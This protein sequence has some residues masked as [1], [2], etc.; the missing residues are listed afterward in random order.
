MSANE[1]GRSQSEGDGNMAWK[2]HA[3][4]CNFPSLA[5]PHTHTFRLRKRNFTWHYSTICIAASAT[6]IKTTTAAAKFWQQQQQ[7]HKQDN[8]KETPFH[9]ACTHTHIGTT[10]DL[11]TH[12]STHDEICLLT[13]IFPFPV[14]LSFP[15]FWHHALLNFSLVPFT[16]THTRLHIR[17]APFAVAVAMS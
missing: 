9:W 4:A 17:V 6:E 15:P 11:F 1:S 7:Q 13:S 14:T 5:P 3:C 16:H 10:P 12:T 8:K 2:T